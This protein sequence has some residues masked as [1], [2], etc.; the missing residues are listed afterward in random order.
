VAL[1]NDTQVVGHDVAGNQLG[2]GIRTYVWDADH[3]LLGIYYDAEPNRSTLFKYDGL[4]R[5]VGI[6]SKNGTS[7]TEVRLLWCGDRI[8]QARNGSDTVTRLYYPEGEVRGSALLYY[9]RDHLGS[10][11][12]VSTVHNGA[13]IASFDYDAYGKTTRSTGRLSPD[14]RYAG[15]YY[16]QEAD[17]YLTQY[18]VYDPRT[19]RWLSRDPIAEDGG[20]NLYGYVGGNPVNAVDP[21][22]ENAVNIIGGVL[23]FISTAKAIYDFCESYSNALDKKKLVQDNTKRDYEVL[24]NLLK[25][26]RPPNNYDPNATNQSVID[27]SKAAADTVVKGAQLPGTIGGGPLADPIVPPIPIAK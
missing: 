22:G 2:D 7:V 25:G 8:C 17:L 13:R 27:F 4:G 6:I 24:D 9:S 3:R 11:R 18:R 1:I 14:F 16:L 20:I 5:R 23:V 12:D 10:V 19:A 26:Q 21:T 15:M